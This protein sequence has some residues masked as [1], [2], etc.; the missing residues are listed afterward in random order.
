MNSYV[1]KFLIAVVLILTMVSDA[2]TPLGVA[3]WV[4]YVFAVL[5][6]LWVERSWAPHVVA[7]IATVL[8]PIGFV[9]SKPG[10]IELW[11]AIFNRV[12]CTAYV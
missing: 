5:L 6:T 1:A 9:L 10:T 7:G 11:V 8:L 2:L 12:A 3:V 4:R